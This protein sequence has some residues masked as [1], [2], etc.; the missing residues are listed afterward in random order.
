L[1]DKDEVRSV[2]IRDQILKELDA[3]APTVAIS[4]R[5][6]DQSKV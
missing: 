3:I 5:N 4:W 2:E 6:H 1:G